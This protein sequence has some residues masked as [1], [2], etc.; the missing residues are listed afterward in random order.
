[1]RP[2]HVAKAKE[3][4]SRSTLGVLLK[5]CVLFRREGCFKVVLKV[6]TAHNFGVRVGPHGTVTFAEAPRT[7]SP[8]QVT[9]CS[10]YGFQINFFIVH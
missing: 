4:V 3:K 7:T 6:I 9:C 10:L 1:M 8:S 2:F 5:T